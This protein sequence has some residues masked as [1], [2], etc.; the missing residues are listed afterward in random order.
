MRGEA[1]WTGGLFWDAIRDSKGRLIGISVLPLADEAE[2]IR[3]SS[4]IETRGVTCDAVSLDLILC[5]ADPMSF[6]GTQGFPV[7]IYQDHEN[8]LILGLAQFGDWGEIA[9][10]V[11]EDGFPVFVR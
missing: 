9:F 8:N 10:A 2:T 5:D 1:E 11:E 4:L 7:L 6:E 3:S